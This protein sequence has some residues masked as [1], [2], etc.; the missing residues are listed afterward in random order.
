MN[1]G[2]NHG[3]TTD[4][5]TLLAIIEIGG[6][7]NFTPVYEAA[8]YEVIIERSTRKAL[9]RLK[10]LSPTI[11]IGEFNYDPQFRDRICNLDSLMSKVQS[12]PDTRVIVF[13]EQHF[14][15]QLA[16]LRKR[17]QDFDALPFPIDPVHLKG[18]LD[19]LDTNAPRDPDRV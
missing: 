4:K 11:I 2:V 10:R 14:A 16:R 15:H 17:F 12:L 7:P 1:H 3:E 13:Y 6:Y 9:N 8:G 19:G 18:F 5:P